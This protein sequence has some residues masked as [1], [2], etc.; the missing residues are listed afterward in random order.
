M[1]Y[2]SLIFRGWILRGKMRS[3]TYLCVDSEDPD[4]EE[5]EYHTF[6]PMLALI[7]RLLPHGKTHQSASRIE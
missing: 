2:V 6:E 5:V 3:I 1:N 4:S 7:S